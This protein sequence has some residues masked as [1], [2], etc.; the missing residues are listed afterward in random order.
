MASPQK[1]TLPVIGITCANCAT[2]IE[3][4]A[5][6]VDGVEDAVVNFGSE[7]VTISYNPATTTLQTVIARIE[8]AGYQIPTATIELPITGMT[9]ANC[10]NT[11]ERTLNKKVPGI[12]EATVNFATEKATVRYIPGTVTQADMVAAIE[13]AGYG[14][15]QIDPQTDASLIDAEQIA[16][17]EEIRRQTR[18][19]MVGLFFTGLIGFIAHNWL[20]L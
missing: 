18:K 4:N 5:K 1:I 17:Q 9:C 2:T 19:L 16:R 8:R 6:K 12:L 20:F 3:R 14:V 15:V 11:V 10:V 7:K 13:R